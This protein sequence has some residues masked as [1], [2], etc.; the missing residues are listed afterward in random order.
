MPL[1]ALPTWKVKLTFVTVAA[2]PVHSPSTTGPGS[3]DVNHG[4][5]VSRAVTVPGRDVTPQNCDT[6]LLW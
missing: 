4:S 6:T 3:T 5:H 2:G 1:G